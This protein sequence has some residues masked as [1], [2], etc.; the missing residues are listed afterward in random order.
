MYLTGMIT[1]KAFASVISR[2]KSQEEEE[3]DNE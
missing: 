2:I 3:E 1:E